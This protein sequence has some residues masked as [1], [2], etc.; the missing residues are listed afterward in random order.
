[1][2]FSVN[3]P[4][5]PSPRIE[6]IFQFATTRPSFP[7]WS[8]VYL[9]MDLPFLTSR[10]SLSRLAD[11]LPLDKCQTDKCQE[12]KC[13]ED[14]CQQDKCQGG[15]VTPGQVPWRTS[16][17]NFPTAS[18]KVWHLSSW[19]LS[20]W[21]YSCPFCCTWP[22]PVPEGHTDTPQVNNTPQLLAEYIQYK[23]IS[24]KQ[25]PP[26]WTTPHKC[27]QNLSNTNSYLR[28]C[29]SPNP[30]PEGHTDTPQLE[31]ILSTIVGCCSLGGVSVCPSGTGLGHVHFL[32]YVF[33]LDIFCQQLWG[34]VHLVGCLC[35]L[36]PQG[37]VINFS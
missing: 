20:S 22:N 7:F 18:K 23:H 11:K 17:P 3:S 12:D 25:I 32:R 28:K 15:Q 30:V 1:M 34:V 31:Y 2:I 35:A 5:R 29:T 16:S 8:V 36:R 19:Y 27:W 26:K 10:A 33:V 6:F 14:K 37:W 24:K 13:Q 9:W 21:Y 4:R